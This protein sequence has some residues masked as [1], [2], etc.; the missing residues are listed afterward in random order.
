MFLERTAMESDSLVPLLC[1]AVRM[2]NLR[3]ELLG[4][5]ALSGW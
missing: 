2:G 1:K 4:T 5:A 3:V